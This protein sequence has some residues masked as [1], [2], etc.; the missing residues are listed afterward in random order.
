MRGRRAGVLCGSIVAAIVLLV[1]P[2][3]WDAS[4]G[5]T[6]LT[7]AARAALLALIA[8]GAW[9][10]VARPTRRPSVPVLLLICAL[11][12]IKVAIGLIDGPQGWVGRYTVVDR[13]P[14]RV[15]PFFW[16]FGQHTFRIDRRLALGWGGFQFDFLNDNERYGQRPYKPSRIEELP[17]DMEW[18]T[19]IRATQNQRLL[20]DVYAKAPV[21]LELDSQ[22]MEGRQDGV[23]W[24]T[25]ATLGAGMHHLKAVY[26]KPAAMEAALTVDIT[27]D[28]LPPRLQA[29][30]SRPPLGRR[31]TFTNDGM[32]LVGLCA[33]LYQFWLAFGAERRLLPRLGATSTSALAAW[34]ACAVVLVTAFAVARPL[35]GISS[36]LSYGDDWLAYES[37]A[38][39]VME[40][41]LLMPLGQAPG[42][43]RPYFFYPLYPY[44]LAGVHWLV[45]DDYAAAVLFNGVFTAA[46]PLTLWALGWRTLPRVAQLIALAVLTATIIHASIYWGA[47]LTDNLFIPLSIAAVAAAAM[48]TLPPHRL[49]A[50][51]AGVLSAFAGATRPSFLL[52][53][54]VYVVAM[55]AYA[56]H[57]TLRERAVRATIFVAMYLIGLSPF[58]ARNYIMSGQF[59][60]TVT[61]SHAITAALIPPEGGVA[62]VK[63]ENH[64]PRW[65]EALRGGL[66]MFKQQPAILLWLEVRKVLFTLGFT[67]LGPPGSPQEVFPAFLVLFAAATWLRRIPGHLMLAIGAFMLSHLA[68]VVIA[69]PWSYGYKT[70]LPV[71]YLMLFCGMFLFAGRTTADVSRPEPAAPVSAAQ[72]STRRGECTA[73]LRA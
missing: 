60:V 42:H 21:D 69:Y 15:A 66:E 10:V 32:V 51:V 5:G 54:L 7:L 47:T 52:F 33:V 16:R 17:I 68:A 44:A 9:L 36:E 6:P 64:P 57:I 25:G 73:W 49:V 55:L 59:V 65:S 37:N 20:I 61:L 67:K 43:G 38:R 41:G 39:N 63:F 58:I 30:D 13:A 27:L 19:W 56:R 34:S 2:G 14:A 29:F 48:A 71:Q 11:V 8:S 31:A 1:S 53:V 3:S 24:R 4:F 62:A 18:S 22:R 70:I 26:R 23:V 28:G 12:P 45:G 50:A 46:V 35:F 72:G 40:E